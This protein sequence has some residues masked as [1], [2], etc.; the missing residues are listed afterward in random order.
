M[1]L[2]GK[3]TTTS[4]T[5]IDPALRRA[6]LDNLAM[7]KKIGQLGPIA[8]TGDTVAGMSPGQ[9]AAIQSGNLGANAFGLREMAVP[10]GANL[11]PYSTYTDALAKI[12]PGQRAF[13]ESLF[14]NPQTGAAPTMTYGAPAAS[15]ARAAAPSSQTAAQTLMDRITYGNGGSGGSS[16]SRGSS[17]SSGRSLSDLAMMAGSYLPGGMN[18]RNSGSLFNTIAADVRNAISPQKAPTSKDRPPARPK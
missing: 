11:N 13:I 2:G 7:A 4:G 1:S 6:A 5:T 3:K 15:S 16:S 8:Y 10:T 9:I 12:P 14:I 17:G 18:T